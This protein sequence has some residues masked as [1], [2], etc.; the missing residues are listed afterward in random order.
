MLLSK[1]NYEI[2]KGNKIAQLLIQPIV[3]AEI[4]EVS[5]LSET[6]RGNGAFGSTGI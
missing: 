4:Q 6:K 5:E 2:K 1:E 3:T